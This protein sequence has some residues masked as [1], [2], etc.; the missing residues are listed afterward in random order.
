MPRP[1]I[2]A[3]LMCRLAHK[4]GFVSASG[5]LFCKLGCSRGGYR[6][7]CDC[8]PEY[9]DLRALVR[10]VLNDQMEGKKDGPYV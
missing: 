8:C 1:K 5:A 3:P 7:C 4:M 9:M 2:K 6:R 10:K